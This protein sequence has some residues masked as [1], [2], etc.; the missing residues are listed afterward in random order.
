MAT[1]MGFLVG[2][3]AAGLLLARWRR[4]PPDFVGQVRADAYLAMLRALGVLLAGLALLTAEF[5]SGR[6]P[7]ATPLRGAAAVLVAIGGVAFLARLA[8]YW[9]RIRPELER[10]RQ[11]LLATPDAA[12]G[13]GEQTADAAGQAVRR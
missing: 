12:G 1:S 5:A 7:L 11:P 6:A 13:D 3:A 10:L 2:L 4:L 8:L 9:R